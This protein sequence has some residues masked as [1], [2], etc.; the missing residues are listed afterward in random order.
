M[1]KY[2]DITILRPRLHRPVGEQCH[3]LSRSSR[4]QCKYTSYENVVDADAVPPFLCQSQRRVHLTNPASLRLVATP[5]NVP[6]N[7]LP[8]VPHPPLPATL[9]TPHSGPSWATSA[10][11]QAQQQQYPQQ[12]QQQRREW[13]G[14]GGRLGWSTTET[15][16]FGAFA[17]KN[18][19]E[20]RPR[21]GGFL[22]QQRQRQQ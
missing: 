6:R 9:Q 17:E 12:Q 2:G 5:Q 8:Q 18:F 10:V 16:G 15:R 4:K 3:A 13:L 11:A 14:A 20:G 19:F 22:S 21:G 1:I 7:P